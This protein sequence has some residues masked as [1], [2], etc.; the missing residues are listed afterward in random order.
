MT[1]EELKQEL[2]KQPQ[3]PGLKIVTLRRINGKAIVEMAASKDG[4]VKLA[5]AISSGEALDKDARYAAF[6]PLDVQSVRALEREGA[7]LFSGKPSFDTMFLLVNRLWI[8]GDKSILEDVM[9]VMTVGS[10][11]MGELNAYHAELGNA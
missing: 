6:R 2:T 8:A 4:A 7:D 10:Q 5:E 9:A 11:L 3:P 1:L